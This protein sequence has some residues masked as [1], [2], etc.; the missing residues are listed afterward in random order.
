MHPLAL[1]EP[2]GSGKFR[3]SPLGA[4]INDL[5]T[6]GLC[7]TVELIPDPLDKTMFHVGI[8]GER[9]IGFIDAGSPTLFMAMAG[10]TRRISFFK[11]PLEAFEYLWKWARAYPDDVIPSLIP[12]GVRLTV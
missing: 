8:D 7:E 9:T 1:T 3:H 12:Q 11:T 6:L 5:Q 10:E 2:D 4:Y